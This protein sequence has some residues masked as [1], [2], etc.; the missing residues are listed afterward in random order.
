MAGTSGSHRLAISRASTMLP[1][2]ITSGTGSLA[3]P[4]R[5]RHAY[6]DRN[7]SIPSGQKGRPTTRLKN[8]GVNPFIGI[9]P[10][11][12]RRRFCSPPWFFVDNSAP[13]NKTPPGR[14]RCRIYPFFSVALAVL[15]RAAFAATV[16][17]DALAALLGC[18][19][20]AFVSRTPG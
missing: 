17:F 4:G 11:F 7:G 12:C 6:A 2:A 5:T 13:L 1:S 16:V 20:A 10:F 19:A 15:R 9:N 18:A 3:A 8:C 14:T